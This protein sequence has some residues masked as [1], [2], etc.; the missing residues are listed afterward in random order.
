MQVKENVS[1]VPAKLATTPKSKTAKPRPKGGSKSSSHPPT[2][3]MVNTAIKELKD[4][5]GSSLQAIKKYIGSAYEV[6][7][8]KF[9][10]FIRRYLKSAVTSGAVVQTKGKGASGS[11][12]L[13]M[14]KGT[15]SRS[16]VL[17]TEPKKSVEKKTTAARKQSSVR[18]PATVKSPAKKPVAVK[19]PASKKSPAK[20]EKSAKSKK[21]AK[22][23]AAKTRTPKP[24][25][26]SVSKTVKPAAKK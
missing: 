13:P 22:A 12:K 26:A 11:F 25:R 5:K 24:R 7:G 6:D 3:E 14:L 8:E 2:S 21:T 16:K 20:T 23:P 15:E 9:A 19:K 4:R 10:P 17:T 18:K 1:T